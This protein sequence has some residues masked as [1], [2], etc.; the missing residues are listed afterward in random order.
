VRSVKPFV[1]AGLAIGSVIG[2]STGVA[3]GGNAVNGV[4][5]FGPI[6]AVV[7]WLF[8][9]Q[10]NRENPGTEI[11]LN[12]TEPP[13]QPLQSDG[14]SLI[15]KTIHAVLA[16]G[17]SMWNVQIYVLHSLG[18]LPSFVEKP[19]LFFVLAIVVSIPFPPIL[20]VYLFAYLGALQFGMSEKTEYRANIT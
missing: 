20:G 5:V 1:L 4:F 2:L 10:G 16:F 9:R 19:W 12:L 3:A 6:G 15:E 7:G 17:A 11:P 8:A 14:L 18:L 13:L